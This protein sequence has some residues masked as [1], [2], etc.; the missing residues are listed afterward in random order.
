MTT[1]LQIAQY[2]DGLLDV[3]NV[4]DYPPALNGLQFE[5]HGAVTK[6]A[7]AV[8]FSSQTITGAIEVEA[9][10]L[11]V[12]HGMFWGGLQPITGPMYNRTKTLIDHNIAVYAAHLPLDCHP[13]FGN[14]V[15]LA[16]AL[17]LTPSSDFAKFKTISIGV[18]GTN[19]VSTSALFD[20]ADA[21]AQLNGGSAR[22]T[23][24]APGQQTNRWAICTGS[25]ASSDTLREAKALD[26]DTLIVGEGPHH[27]A[28]E[29]VELGITVI[30]AGHY[31]T[32]TLGVSAIATHLTER[33]NIPST[34]IEAP[35]SL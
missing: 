5:S 20:K 30:Y 25:G 23:P 26:I 27:T 24:I 9:N 22:S 32:E 10:L 29:A 35:T 8:D 17:N 16:Q 18:R 4:P 14:N 15:L 3:P 13:K 33:F 34:F 28:V 12:H 19:S 21:F 6:I 7:A 11:V 31:A 2:L 1:S